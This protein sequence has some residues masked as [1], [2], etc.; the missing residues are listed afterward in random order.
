MN[1]V[2]I[3]TLGLLIVILALQIYSLNILSKFQVKQEKP[4]APEILETKSE[5]R[6][7]CG[8]SIENY[9]AV[10]IYLPTCPFSMRMKPLVENSDL[11]WYWINP[12]DSRCSSINL[13][14]FNFT[15][16]VPHFYCL[17]TGESHTGA[18]PEEEFNNWINQCK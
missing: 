8:N 6:V 13:T 5:W 3:A 11:N 2:E 4:Q 10:F 14:K 15:G 18:L 7:D 1:K 16:F 12:Y 17:K 9:D